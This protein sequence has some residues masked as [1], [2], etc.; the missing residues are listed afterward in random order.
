MQGN[1]DF[2]NITF[3]ESNSLELMPNAKN[4]QTRHEISETG[5]EYMLGLFHETA[6]PRESK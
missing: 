3:K 2:S 5:T 6:L 4:I 1:I